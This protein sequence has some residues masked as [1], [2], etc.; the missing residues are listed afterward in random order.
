MDSKEKEE[1][2]KRLFEQLHSF[3]ELGNQDFGIPLSLCRGFWLPTCIIPTWPQYK[4]FEFRPTDVTVISPP[5]CGPFFDLS[6]TFM[7][8]LT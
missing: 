2:S 5:K 6:L 7:T 8:H 1:V 4:N 3:D